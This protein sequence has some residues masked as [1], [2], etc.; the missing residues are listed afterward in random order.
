[1]TTEG[2]ELV[3]SSS[4]APAMMA[5]RVDRP[6]LASINA[7][8]SPTTPRKPRECLHFLL[9]GVIDRNGE[10]AVAVHLLHL[11]EEIRA[12]IRTPLEDVVLPLVDHFMR[13]CA[14]EFVCPKRRP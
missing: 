9:Q 13:H 8:A 1:T 2:R 6:P 4:A 10:C 5:G 12:M 7:P 3:K 14:D 11:A